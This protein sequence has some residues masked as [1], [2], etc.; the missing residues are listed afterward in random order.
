MQPVDVP[1]TELCGI[2]LAGVEA[3]LLA[4]SRAR[5]FALWVGLSYAVLLLA[6]AAPAWLAL[7][8]AYD[9]TERR[10]HVS[11]EA[12]AGV[13]AAVRS[14][15]TALQLA[16]HARAFLISG[17]GAYRAAMEAARTSF[18]DQVQ[19][20]RE[21]S[22]AQSGLDGLDR[23]E[24]A[25][26]EYV[27]ALERMT[28]LRGQARD[29]A[30]DELVLLFEHDMAPRQRELSAALADYISVREAHAR[31]ANVTAQRAFRDALQAASV[32]VLL[33]LLA[34]LGL[35]VRSARTLAHWYHAEREASRRAQ[36]AVAA[37][38]ELLGVVAH[39]LRS[40]LAAISL[41]AGTI[42]RRS[43]QSPVLGDAQAIENVARRMDALIRSLLD[44]ALI[45]KGQFALTVAPARV[46]A[47][48]AAVREI[49]SSHAAVKAIHL[50]FRVEDPELQVVADFER[51]VQAVGNIVGNAIK[52]TPA[53]GEIT[54]SARQDHDFVRISIHDSGPG[55]S[56]EDQPHIFDR[57]WKQRRGGPRGAGLG[58]FIAKTVVDAH[59][60]RIWVTSAPG[61]GSIFSLTLPRSTGGAPRE[62]S[63]G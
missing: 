39:D 21:Q 30:S 20:L 63:D 41:K 48:F 43:E 29:E 49:F 18:F 16:S 31:E 22:Q 1:S 34:G 44:V 3:K 33:G 36:D 9:A 51:V 53:G 40:P 58:L 35:G 5:R 55:I 7:R 61:R 59:G 15:E 56:A 57:F 46:H 8:R 45:E 54:V 11:A 52:F 28:A 37:R 19:A 23:I 13:L 27:A 47:L 32:L 26:H 42:Q 25:V 6:V 10:D 17:D 38:D 12:I 4:M 14:E 2:A 24:R 62:A 50:S 60:G